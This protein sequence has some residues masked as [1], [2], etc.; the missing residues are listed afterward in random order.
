[1]SLFKNGLETVGRKKTRR[2]ERKDRKN[3]L[4][5]ADHLDD[6]TGSMA[7]LAKIA[8][9]SLGIPKSVS[10]ERFMT[11]DSVLELID[12][13]CKVTD[14]EVVLEQLTRLLDVSERPTHDRDVWFNEVERAAGDLCAEMD[15][16]MECLRMSPQKPLSHNRGAIEALSNKAW[17]NLRGWWK[18]K[19]ASD[20]DDFIS[21]ISEED[22]VSTT[23][24]SSFKALKEAVD[25]SNDHR[26]QSSSAQDES[27]FAQECKSRGIALVASG[28]EEILTAAFKTL[29]KDK[30][31]VLSELGKNV[32]SGSHQTSMELTDVLYDN[33]GDALD[34][35]PD[36]HEAKSLGVEECSV[37]DNWFFMSVVETKNHGKYVLEAKHK[38][39]PIAKR[40]NYQKLAAFADNA[41]AKYRYK[42]KGIERGSEDILGVIS[43]LVE[44]DETITQ[45]V[46]EYTLAI[47]KLYDTHK[48]CI[49]NV[50]NYI[51][52]VIKALDIVKD[53]AGVPA[54]DSGSVGKEKVPAELAK[55]VIDYETCY[56]YVCAEL[57]A[58]YEDG[59]EV[60]V[61]AENF[62]MAINACRD[63]T[64][65]EV[66]ELEVDVQ[67]LALERYGKR[68]RKLGDNIWDALTRLYKAIKLKIL[69]FAYWVTGNKYKL[70]KKS[71]KIKYQK[72][73]E[74][75]IQIKAI[76]EKRKL[77][78]PTHKASP[79]LNMTDPILI[80]KF[81]M[82]KYRS[83]LEGC[84]K[85]LNKE[86]TDYIRYLSAGESV[87][88]RGGD[89]QAYFNQQKHSGTLETVF[90]GHNKTISDIVSG[91]TAAHMIK[92]TV[93]ATFKGKDMQGYANLKFKFD[94][95]NLSMTHDET[96]NNALKDVFATL[97]QAGIRLNNRVLTRNGCARRSKDL[98]SA[99]KQITELEKLRI[100]CLSDNEPLLA[101]FNADMAKL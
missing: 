14:G 92:G 26:S 88:R 20:S 38:D 74:Y 87:V 50:K 64:A 13:K 77:K 99:W 8:R 81:L 3:L 25:I 69:Q 84:F 18:S 89:A 1:M 54:S 61:A 9:K 98:F 78:F 33:I 4:V 65:T 40:I 49:A 86:Y 73:V 100:E 70:K 90:G 80:N 41:S 97:R 32:Q 36:K 71:K 76:K 101:K 96:L 83:A 94:P 79:Q 63:F 48:D 16:P 60:L 62:N 75:T 15:Y 21:S 6:R 44:S 24:S 52:E 12:P 45:E 7:K 67:D 47:I 17:G 34:L 59:E 51:G 11:K 93:K 39:Q 30:S 57:D 19:L 23:L 27:H 10:L 53:E 2:R 28:E 37:N 82:G 68:V 35:T 91:K 72:P 43:S 85:A 66:L 56:T 42:A 46:T 29:L 58:E 31:S 5:I 95:I 22:T 55:E